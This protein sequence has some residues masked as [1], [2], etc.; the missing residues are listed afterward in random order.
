MVASGHGRIRPNNFATAL[1][2]I[3]IGTITSPENCSTI[4]TCLG[5]DWHRLQTAGSRM[6][7]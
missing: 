2:C 1:N 7:T 6:K 3:L 4:G 5:N